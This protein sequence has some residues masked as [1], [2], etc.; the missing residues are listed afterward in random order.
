MQSKNDRKLF[1]QLFPKNIPQDSNLS[2][3]LATLKPWYFFD[4][5]TVLFVSMC[6]P[7][8]NVVA[9]I[10]KIII[11][12]IIFPNGIKTYIYVSFP[13]FLKWYNTQ[14]CY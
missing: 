1:L 4:V 12:L 3:T 9:L 13:V 5:A 6:E 10:N 2:N 7:Q 14:T 11:F 8:M